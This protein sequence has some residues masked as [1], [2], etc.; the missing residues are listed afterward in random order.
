MREPFQMPKPK[1]QK[2]K[3]LTPYNIDKRD[4]G[5]VPGKYGTRGRPE[6]DR[7]DGAGV[8]I[9]TGVPLVNPDPAVI[10]PS[11][12]YDKKKGKKVKVQ[13]AE[14]TSRNYHKVLS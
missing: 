1:E 11:I 4:M 8:P 5:V 9:P 14:V 13:F 6:F 3:D 10:N 2:A 7:V 12:K